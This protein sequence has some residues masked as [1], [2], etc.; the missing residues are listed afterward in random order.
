VSEV[1]TEPNPPPTKHLVRV[2]IAGSAAVFLW[3][4]AI[5]G[6]IVHM[7][8]PVD[9]TLIN[10]VIAFA[11]CATLIACAAGADYRRRVR[12]VLAGDDWASQV[13][14]MLA[15]VRD[16]AVRRDEA[17]TRTMRVGAVARH[18]EILDAVA[19]LADAVRVVAEQSSVP[20]PTLAAIHDLTERIAAGPGG[21]NGSTTRG[22][23]PDN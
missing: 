7:A 2:A 21:V 12:A 11:S 22:A 6:V 5:T 8:T 19:V 13:R 17:L 16:E 3:I 20:A 15:D 4:A 14:D 18:R 23:R 10:L 9:N 1:N